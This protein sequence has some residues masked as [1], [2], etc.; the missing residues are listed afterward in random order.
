MVEILTVCTGNICRSPL[1]EVL[2]RARLADLAPQVHSAGTYGL[3]AEP[4]TPEAHRLAVEL[5]GDVDTAAA[6]RSRRLLEGS[7]GTPHLILG[8]SREHRQ[9]V[10]ELAPARLRSTFTLREFARLAAS[11]STAEIARAVAGAPQDISAR[12]RSAIA[13]VA[14]R[15]AEVAPPSAPEDDDIIDPYGRSWQTYQLSASQLAPAL[16]Q[17]ERILRL[18]ITPG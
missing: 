10:I 16:D 12:I 14:D 5:G 6:H 17:V 15:R 1:A 2:L 9:R 7:L 18:A 3:D 11:A 4:M 13:V 8:M